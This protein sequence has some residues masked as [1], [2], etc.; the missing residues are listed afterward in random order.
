MRARRAVAGLAVA[1][2]LGGLAAC[3]DDDGKKTA[4]GGSGGD[5]GIGCAAA[6]GKTVG[7]SEPLPDPNF[8]ALEKILT[9]SLGKYG[10]KLRP[11][12]A[13][14]NPGKQISDIQTLLQQRVDVLIANP[15]DP[16][17][18]QGAFAQ[19]RQKKIPIIVLDTKVGGPYYTS[20]HDDVEYAAAEGAR[21]LK[22]LAA[23]GKVAAIY[24]P[25]FAELLNWEKAAF[26]AAAKEAG[27]DVVDRQVNQKITPDAAKGIAE[28]WRQKYG[29]QLKG[30][31]T[32]NDVSA[33][34]AASAIG[35]DFKPAIV[36]INGQPD[37]IPLVQA[38]KISMTFGVP[39]DKTGQAMAYAALRALCGA[40]VPAEIT[41]PTVKI[42]KAGAGSWQPIAQR[43]D[44]PFKV[45]FEQRAGKTYVKLD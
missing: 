7:F 3:G 21:Q 4:A 30:I 16:N 15:V 26:D 11:V 1:A 10:A 12:N 6:K 2:L 40:K 27:L 23:G 13:N 31:W 18:T 34:G 28:A 32:F 19:A 42:D 24:G 22:T 39:Y 25:S 29:A 33:I 44:N 38:G 17:A 35:G 20:V 37:A 9:K 45:A 43:V 36:S 5:D 41:V 8:Q 14:L